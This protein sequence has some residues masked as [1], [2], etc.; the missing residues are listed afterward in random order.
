MSYLF[1]NRMEGHTPYEPLQI[2]AKPTWLQPAAKLAAE[3]I[4]KLPRSSEPRCAG[5]PHNEFHL[6]AK[7]TQGN[8]KQPGCPCS[9]ANNEARQGTDEPTLPIQGSNGASKTRSD[10]VKQKCFQMASSWP[11]KLQSRE[12]RPPHF[13]RGHNPVFVVAQNGCFQQEM[14]G[15]DTESKIQVGARVAISRAQKRRPL[16][17]PDS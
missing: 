16:K 6:I 7:A 14:S 15:T 11:L 10:S 17:Y 8:F 2:H 13:F 3:V 9:A 12:S 1:S 4:V 5:E